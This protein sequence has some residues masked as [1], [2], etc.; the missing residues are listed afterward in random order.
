MAAAPIYHIDMN[1]FWADPYPDLKEM[2]RLHP[3]VYVPELDAFLLTLR[4][5][6]FENEK[7]IDVF[8]SVQ[9][10]GLMV[11]LMGQN[12]MRKDGADHMR[13]RK[14]AFPTVSPKTVKQVWKTKFQSAMNDVLNDVLRHGRADFV[15]DIAMRISGEALKIVTGL[16][17]IS[18][19][20]MDR[21]SQGMIDGCANYIGDPAVEENC[22]ECTAAIDDYITEL[23]PLYRES[24]D[25]SLLSILMEAGLPETSI[26]AN[27]K[28]AI[29]GGQNEPRDVIAGLTWA[30]LKH[31]EQ[32]E[33]IREGQA[34][35]TQAFNEYTRWIS[36]VGMSP[37]RIAC[38]F[39][40][41]G[42]TLKPDDKVFLM[43]SA[44]NRD[45]SHFTHP[46]DFNLKQDVSKAITFGAG[47]H[48]CAGAAVSK[49]LIAEVVVPTV[50]ERLDGLKLDS[51]VK[52]GGWA[53]RGP[54]SMPVRWNS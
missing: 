54:V 15:E 7:K 46:N 3:V 5:D 53:F 18:W 31:P 12:M 40:L 30:L 45:E 39:D 37:R 42:V 17:Q 24:P 13:E 29:S 50:F 23:M 19:K 34:T 25:H 47:P 33:L 27:V 8:S 44:A 14:A 6:I 52:F 21:V 2:S 9:P 35:W 10:N 11:K 36:P 51:T 16:N 4:D 48:F 38:E 22:H 41:H 28:L 20:E 26:R 49:C 43:F 1:E 32:L